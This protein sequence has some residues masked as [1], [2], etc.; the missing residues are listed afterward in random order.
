M[1]F[2]LL[3]F[4]HYTLFLVHGMERVWENVGM[5]GVWFGSFAFLLSPGAWQQK[6][7]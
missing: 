5:E 1:D 7:L 6:L 3:L 4:A 2:T